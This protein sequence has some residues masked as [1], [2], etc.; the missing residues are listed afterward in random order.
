MA[1]EALGSALLVSPE[2]I[3]EGID[4]LSRGQQHNLGIGGKLKAIVGLNADGIALLIR[5]KA[6][7]CVPAFLLVISCKIC[8]DDMEIG[9]I[10]YEMLVQFGIMRRFPASRVQM[11]QLAGS[12]SGY[13][14]GLIPTKTLE[15]I[16]DAISRNTGVAAV[17]V[18]IFWQAN[19]KSIAEILS[20]TF[21]ALLKD[22]IK[23]ITL[24]GDVGGAFLAS[25]LLWLLADEF[26]L[27]LDG[28]I[29]LGQPDAK[30]LLDLT[31]Q[32]A[33]R[34]IIQ[35]WQAQ[36]I[37]PEVIVKSEDLLEPETSLVKF[38]GA[39]L[40]LRVLSA[41]FTLDS[42]HV[43]VVGQL[44]FALVMTSFKHGVLSSD[45]KFFHGSQKTVQL[46]EICQTGFLGNLSSCMAVFG[47]KC[48]EE[49]KSRAQ[50]L[51]NAMD[52]WISSGSP[53][54][55]EPEPN[56]LRGI[57]NS[58]GLYMYWFF[59]NV[60]AWMKTR[61]GYSDIRLD[62]RENV[63]D[64]AIFLAAEVLY[65]SVCDILPSFRSLRGC[66]P[67]TIDTNARTLVSLIFVPTQMQRT[68]KLPQ[69]NLSTISVCEFRRLAMTSLLPGSPGNIEQ[70]DLVSSFNGYVVFA[71]P[72]RRITTIPRECIAVSIIPG[73][74]RWGEDKSTFDRIRESRTFIS[75]NQSSETGS[76]EVFDQEMAKYLGLQPRM[77]ESG[78][79]VE[80]LISPSGKTLLVRTYMHT[81]QGRN[82]PAVEVDW[83]SSIN[84]VA[85]SAQVD[86]QN[87]LPAAEE[88][89][90]KIWLKGHIWDSMT[91][92]PAHGAITSVRSRIGTP[93]LHGPC[94]LLSMTY[95]NERLR[96]FLAG[97][98]KG[99]KVYMRQ[100]STPLMQCVRMALEASLE[101][102]KELSTG[103]QRA[104]TLA[105]KGEQSKVRIASTVPPDNSKSGITVWNWIVIS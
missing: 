91:W 86:E 87:M 27:S 97:R 19:T 30:V 93:P 96:F 9:D 57:P 99:I 8:F 36:N 16:T 74:I 59:D 34:W 101:E 48:N 103:Q 92:V 75:P 79:E 83:L 41:Q 90:A 4:A 40:G 46:S 70:Y 22:N 54:L 10:L 52:H 6:T 55:T 66:T 51:F 64:P 29:I 45:P 32:D 31:S 18:K 77:D 2:R 89:L 28:V 3:G 76:V 37:L 49:F 104:N 42:N 78:L 58:P 24:Q 11:G 43:E 72:L 12:I 62:Y 20:R 105:A 65:G 1:F 73:V 56:S 47:W 71:A 88:A 15:T 13:G 80:S 84:A 39:S 17:P 50:Q 61:P 33:D 85:V 102:E 44:A 26:G 7:Q 25:I 21:G 95:G 38:T 14:D 5:K 81:L 68:P 100:G 82:G 63:L 53:S 94:N 98:C 69:S 67:G 60:E 35:E 23:R